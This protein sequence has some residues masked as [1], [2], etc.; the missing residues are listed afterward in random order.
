MSAHQLARLIL[1]IFAIINAAF[2]PPIY[3]FYPETKGLSLESVDLLFSKNHA[4][5]FEEI[6]QDNAH[7]EAVVENKAVELEDTYRA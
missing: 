4:T 3:F 1:Q 5:T 7:Q 6:K 2:L